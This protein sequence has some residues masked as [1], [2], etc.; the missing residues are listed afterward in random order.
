MKRMFLCLIHLLFRE[1]KGRP[2][3]KELDH[4]SSVYGYFESHNHNGLEVR[5]GLRQARN[6]VRRIKL[7]KCPYVKD[8]C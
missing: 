7:G 8:N 1:L 4:W 6:N 5:R 2:Q 3:T